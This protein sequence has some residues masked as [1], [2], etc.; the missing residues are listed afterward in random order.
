MKNSFF[1]KNIP[2]F[3]ILKFLKK[4]NN[5]LFVSTISFIIIG[6]MTFNVLGTRT[7]STAEL[8][9]VEKS[10]K[11]NIVGSMM[12]A[13]C[14]SGGTGTI[15][16]GHTTACTWT[17]YCTGPDPTYNWEFWQ[18][19]NDNTVDYQKIADTCSSAPTSV[20]NTC[21]AAGTSVTLNWSG[22]QGDVS[23]YHLRI[24]V[25][26]VQSCPSGWTR[27]Y[28]PAITTTCLINNYVPSSIVVPINPSQNYSW[29]VHSAA[30][31]GFN[32]GPTYGGFTCTPP[33]T[34]N[35]NFN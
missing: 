35:I 9:F 28:D 3:P 30:V 15:G 17:P 6:V 20:S 18:Y 13:S 14:E 25:P 23:S 7:V 5:I 29:W 8:R 24:S 33:P 1:K 26:T 10:T 16:P 11:N 2:L 12:P 32:S 31:S 21:N 4:K 19:S 34:V 27:Y 22:A